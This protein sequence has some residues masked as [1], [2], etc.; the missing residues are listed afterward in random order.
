[1]CLNVCL[2]LTP[3]RHLQLGQAPKSCC[4]SACWCHVHR[5]PCWVEL[6]PIVLLDFAAA[7]L[8]LAVSVGLLL[9]GLAWTQRSCPEVHAQVSGL[10]D[11]RLV[12]LVTNQ[13]N[14]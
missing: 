3:S 6:S 2:T 14:V 12:V 9:P 13:R 1:M 4:W 10:M 7:F 5:T 11:E 8:S